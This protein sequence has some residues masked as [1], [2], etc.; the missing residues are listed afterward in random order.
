MLKLNKIFSLKNL[1]IYIFSY[2]FITIYY[3]YIWQLPYWIGTNQQYIYTYYFTKFTKH[4]S[5]DFITILIYI[6]IG[7]IIIQLL[8]YDCFYY[9]ILIQICAIILITGI[10]FI[11]YK[12]DLLKNTIFSNW[13][14][15]IG[16]F[17]ILY[18]LF[19]ILSIY[20]TMDFLDSQTQ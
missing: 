5:F 6:V 7:E 10:L 11:L 3:I 9:K 18:D 14:Q 12:S 19:I 15:Y 8:Q 16:I 4:I 13:F 20:L 2:S 1:F 17:K